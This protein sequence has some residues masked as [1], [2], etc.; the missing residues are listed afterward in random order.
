MY[1]KATELRSEFPAETISAKIVRVDFASDRRF[2]SHPA[3]AISIRD[4]S[5]SL[6]NT[7]NIISVFKNH[8]LSL[9]LKILLNT[10]SIHSDY[11]N[12]ITDACF[13]TRSSFED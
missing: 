11:Q 13:V 9:S 10:L 6:A 7:G 1:Q 3:A 8:S 4:L 12:E 5:R 2:V